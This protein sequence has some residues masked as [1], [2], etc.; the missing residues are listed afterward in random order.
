MTMF[1]TT[2]TLLIATLAVAACFPIVAGARADEPKKAKNVILFIG[3]G[4]G[5]NSEIMGSYY[6]TGKPWGESYQN[7]PIVLGSA[8]FSLHKHSNGVTEWDP[9][10]EPEKNMGYN[11]EEFWKNPGNAN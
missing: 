11:P 9:V 8:T 5:F 2:R 10:K 7:F 6:H 1:K 4:D 3:D